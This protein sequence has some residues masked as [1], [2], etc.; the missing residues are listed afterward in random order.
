MNAVKAISSIETRAHIRALLFR[1]VTTAFVG[2][3]IMG[4]S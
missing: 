4:V 3:S 2:F 1:T